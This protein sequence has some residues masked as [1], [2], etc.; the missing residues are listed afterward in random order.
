MVAKGVYPLM[1]KITPAKLTTACCTQGL[2]NV[3]E[4]GGGRGNWPA[5]QMIS[6]GA[7]L[8]TGFLFIYQDFFHLFIYFLFFIIYLFIIIIFFFFGGELVIG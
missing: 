7:G 5:K 3:F 8:F 2:W 4:R 1:Y 6:R